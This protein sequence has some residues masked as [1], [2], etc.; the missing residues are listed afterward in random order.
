MKVDVY[1]S[2]EMCADSR[3]WKHQENK[4]LPRAF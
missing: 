1:T 2:E 3:T 4:F